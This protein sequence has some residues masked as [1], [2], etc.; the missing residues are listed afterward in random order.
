M[1]SKSNNKEYISS[2]YSEFTEDDLR[3]AF[4]LENKVDFWEE[5]IRNYCLI[6][7]IAGFTLNELIEEFTLDNL[8]PSRNLFC[9]KL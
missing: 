3:D 9:K 8:R 6:N 5:K 4:L 7:K 2:M 1:D